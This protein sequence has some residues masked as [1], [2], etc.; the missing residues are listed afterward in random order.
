MQM[1]ESVLTHAYCGVFF[2]R[3]YRSFCS[4]ENNALK[5]NRL[6]LSCIPA[7]FTNTANMPPDAGVFASGITFSEN[8]FG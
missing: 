4:W 6:R 1:R 2:D 7:M 8:N 5:H 3:D